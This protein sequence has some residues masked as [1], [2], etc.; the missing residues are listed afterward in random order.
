MSSPSSLSRSVEA[1]AQT[2]IQGSLQMLKFP[3]E[4]QALRLNHLCFLLLLPQTSAPSLQ[5]SRRFL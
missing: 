4:T 1:V 3:P 2:F 5:L